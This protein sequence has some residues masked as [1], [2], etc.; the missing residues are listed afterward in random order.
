[1]NISTYGQIHAVESE[2]RL[3]RKIKREF[4]LQPCED[5][6]NYQK[7]VKTK[8]ILQRKSK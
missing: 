4:E 7:D 1:M 5:Q 3:C 8:K 6:M 2:I